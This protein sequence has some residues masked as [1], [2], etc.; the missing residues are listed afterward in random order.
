MAV[1]YIE[2][3][4]T[5][6]EFTPN[7][8]LA[9]D[10]ET[11]GLYG[12]IRLVQFYQAS[13]DKVVLVNNPNPIQLAALLQN[14]HL[15]GHNLHY[16]ISCLQKQT[17][18]RWIPNKFDDTLFLSRLH[19][20][21]KLEFS[22][23]DVLHYQLGH[24]PYKTAGLNK[25]VLQKSNWD[26]L[27]L[28]EEQKQYA[29]ID[30]YYMPELFETT[31][32]LLDD[33]SYKLDIKTCRHALDFQCN[34]LP[35]IES[36]VATTYTNNVE[37]IAK[38]DMPI[39]VNSWQQ[40]RKYIGED[41]SDGLALATF[42]L[43]GNDKA[44]KVREVKKLIK[45]NSFLDKFDSM[46]NRIYGLFLPSARSGRF[47]SKNQNLQQ[48]PRAL[49]HVFGWEQGSGMCL[50]YA[51][52]AQL[53]MRTIAAITGDLRMAGV[54]RAN[55]DLHDFTAKMLFGE[56]FTPTQRQIAK[57][58]NFNLLYGGGAGM[59]RSILIKD[60]DLLIS[61][62][63]AAS[64]KKR[65]QNL[66]HTVNSWQ[67][68]GIEAFHRGTPWRTPFGRKYRAKMMTDQLNIK[69][70]GAGAEVAKLAMCYMYEEYKDTFEPKGVQL[71]DFVHD[72]YVFEAPEDPEI[73]TSLADLLA[74]SMQEA[75]FEFLRAG[76]DLR[77]RDLPMPVDVF[78]GY[79]WGSIEKDPIY[80]LKLDGLHYANF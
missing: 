79:N 54:L 8:P 31:K 3:E 19:W 22:L 62:E 18:T 49:K 44:R 6:I 20:F 23:D 58:C 65:W 9:F 17:G 26:V 60:A 41:E 55:E 40:V 50:V 71:V 2:M 52:Y 33:T 12:R 25:T 45:Q 1:P 15:L 74:K 10:S 39:N 77:I 13:W 11:C 67:E 48:L 46:D 4:L 63:E 61:M 32:H 27:V 47:T 35:V 51:D 36:A 73:Y 43:H 42:A 53:E 76:L 28:T 70:Q 64:A 7:E 37:A 72:S 29:A 24:D 68:T 30:V 69:N 75:W 21:A 34:G 66:Y 59:L 16:D 57:T 5:D 38:A 78:V 56:N 80:K 14:K